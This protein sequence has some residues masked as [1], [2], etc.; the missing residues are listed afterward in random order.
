MSRKQMEGD[1]QRRRALA[2]E[3]RERGNQPGAQSATLGSSKQTG[4]SREPSR[5]PG[6]ATPERPKPT[7]ARLGTAP[8][9]DP[10]Y[11]YGEVTVEPGD[12]AAPLTEEELGA[13]LDT[14][15]YWEGTRSALRRTI[16][17]PEDN[18]DR[19]LARI[20]R[21]RGDTGRAP[22]VVRDDREN[23]TIVLNSPSLNA[24]TGLDVALAHQVDATIDEAGAGIAG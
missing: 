13:A 20:D 23:A 12:P 2:R 14:L 17:L 10:R 3:S 11:R 22:K 19:V 6:P 21:L 1:N 7:P 15:P 4:A 8:P 18:L 5:N 16:S 9:G 24:A